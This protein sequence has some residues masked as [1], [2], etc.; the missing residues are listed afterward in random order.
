MKAVENRISS[1]ME[2]YLEAIA[3]LKKDKGVARVN[4]IGK[5]LH[6]KNS[7]VN[8]ALA[9][10]ARSSLILHERY[11]T[12]ELTR[13]GQEIADDV[14]GRHDMVFKF[15]SRI[16]EINDKIA[17][18]DA[19]KIEHAIS[20]ITFE[21]LAKFIRFVETG[22]DGES[23]QWLKS[24]KYYLRTGKKLKCGMRRIAKKKTR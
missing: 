4:D 2:D 12:V 5:I 24:F 23:P 7:S 11:G 21:R 16:L 9:T 19:C 1:N 8:A 17:Q 10:L 18:A 3:L 14:Q 20:P 15:L 13:K 22:L 6:V